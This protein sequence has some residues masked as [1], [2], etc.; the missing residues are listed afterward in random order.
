MEDENINSIKADFNSFIGKFDDFDKDCQTII[1]GVSPILEEPKPAPIPPFD[2]KEL[3]V[4]M[5]DTLALINSKPSLTLVKNL[6]ETAYEKFNVTVRTRDLLAKGIKDLQKDAATK[7]T[8]MHGLIKLNQEFGSD[9]QRHK[10][11]TEKMIEDTEKLLQRKEEIDAKR[12]EFGDKIKGLEA[13]HYDII[14]R[15]RELT[16]EELAQNQERKVELEKIVEGLNVQMRELEKSNKTLSEKI[17]KEAENEKSKLARKETNRQR[18]EDSERRITDLETHKVEVQGLIE[19]LK[20]TLGKNEKAYQLDDERLTTNTQQ[21]EELADMTK[22][23]IKGREK[24]KEILY[25]HNNQILA[26]QKERNHAVALTR[27][28]ADQVEKLKEDQKTLEEEFQELEKAKRAGLKRKGVI[29]KMIKEQKN[30]AG[31]LEQDRY[32]IELQLADL[33]NVFEAKKEELTAKTDDMEKEKVRKEELDKLI[34][35]KKHGLYNHKYELMA[36]ERDIKKAENQMHGTE[37]EIKRLATRLDQIKQLQ[38]KYINEAS[39]AHARFYQAVENLRVKNYLIAELQTNNK[40]LAKKL[41]QQK[42]LYEAVRNDRNVYSKTLIDLKDEIVEFNK[43]YTALNH[44]VKHL[45]EEINYKAGE[46]IELTKT[47]EFVKNENEDAKTKKA[48]L[49][50]KIKNIEQNIKFYQAEINNLKVL[51]TEANIEK[52][53]K[54]NVH[55]NIAAERDL[56]SLQLFKRE[57]EM[58]KLSEKLKGVETEL[59]LD[60][61][62]YNELEGK[63]SELQTQVIECK[64][65]QA[66]LRG[67][68]TGYMPLKIETIGVMRELLDTQGRVAA[69]EHQ[70]KLPLNL[71]RWRALEATHPEKYAKILKLQKLQKKLIEKTTEVSKLQGE[72]EMRERELDRLKLEAARNVDSGNKAQVEEIKVKIKEK[73]A[74]IRQM[75]FEL[76]EAQ[77]KGD[78]LRLNIE[79][80]DGKIRRMEDEYFQRRKMEEANRGV[81]LDAK[82][83]YIVN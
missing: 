47:H 83:N 41:K 37:R 72:I 69:M 16:K 5:L 59:L 52:R 76:K 67:Q 27:N 48:V 12:A 71:H 17:E 42:A 57:E 56:L 11:E 4:A 40:E 22:M 25:D 75:L 45:K 73:T 80:S 38:E 74:G 58:T 28:Y 66:E 51:I 36:I 68:L 29:E 50:S 53:K 54:V 35:Q 26:K 81:E 34:T 10:L 21:L 44:Q 3:E 23:V 9:F 62:H 49:K 18:I 77:K 61:N 43:N 30:E 46:V 33:R 15:E 79:I 63:V 6:I 24:L 20:E 8:K 64:N 1:E 65:A 2:R 55:E 70:L 32:Y 82:E 78:E 31:Q 39:L 60:Q 7:R 13:E 14:D 19:Q